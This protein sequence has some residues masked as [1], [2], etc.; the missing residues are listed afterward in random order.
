MLPILS[1][2]IDVYVFIE[3]NAQFKFLLLKR[4]KGNRYENLWHP[5]S[6]KIKDNEKAYEAALREFQEETSLEYSKIYHIDFTNHF[7]YHKTN[8][9]YLYPC[10]AIETNN[11]D[12]VLNHEHSEFAWFS[13]EEAQ[14]HL[15][16]KNH[17]DALEQVY[18]DIC[19]KTYPEKL[20]LL[21]IK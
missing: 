10:F 2:F 14:K 17:R 18:S 16:W 19:L 1:K 13:F 3:T 7:Y 8:E 6:G 12:V 20:N 21:E 11:E 15:V 4:S 9:N 5:V